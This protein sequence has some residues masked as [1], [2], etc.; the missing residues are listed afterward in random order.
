MGEYYRVL[1]SRILGVAI[2]E[3]PPKRVATRAT[4]L[5]W[6]WSFEGLNLNPTFNP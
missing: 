6:A 1:L 4:A 2:I 5:R 3:A